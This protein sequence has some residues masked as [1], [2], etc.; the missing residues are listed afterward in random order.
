VTIVTAA[1]PASHSLQVEYQLEDTGAWTSLGTLS[2]TNATTATYSFAANIT[3]K[4]IAFRLTLTGVA[5]AAVS[6]VL[7]ELSL[8]YTPRPA[9]TREWEIAVVLQGTAELPLATLDGAPDPQT[10]AQLTTALWTA[11]SA[12]GP[13]TFVDIDSTSY[14]VYVEDVREEMAKVSQRKG[15]QRVGL[16]RLVEAA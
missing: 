13:V 8:R 2:T 9:V 4:Q 1:M 10:G 11:A 5:G 7:Y 3:G 12:A 16:C 15:Y 6:P 14:S